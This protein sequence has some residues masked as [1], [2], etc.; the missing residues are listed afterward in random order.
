MGSNLFDHPNGWIG[1]TPWWKD[2]VFYQVYPASFKD[3]NGD[4]WGDIPGLISKIDYLHQLGVDVV[5]LS[6]MFESPQK[7]MGY[8]ISDYQAVYA[9]YGTLEDVDQ[10]IDACHSRGMKLILDLVVNHTSDQHP[11]F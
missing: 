2:A 3:S 10:L 9:R 7:D 8:D 4:G 1:K 5:W 11:W 6:P